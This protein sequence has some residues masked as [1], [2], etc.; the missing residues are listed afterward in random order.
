MT[1]E[2][3]T[4]EQFQQRQR[5]RDERADVAEEARA[6]NEDYV[7][8]LRLL[9]TQQNSPWGTTAEV[10]LTRMSML[11]GLKKALLGRRF[12]RFPVE[13]VE[14]DGMT[15]WDSAW[16][17]DSGGG[18]LN[19]F[20]DLSDFACPGNG[21]LVERDRWLAVSVVPVNP[22]VSSEFDLRMKRGYLRRCQGKWHMSDDIDGFGPVSQWTGIHYFPIEPSLLRGPR[23]R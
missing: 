18:D 16:G 12:L 7:S 19:P 8:M 21:P 9:N 15:M 22:Y 23:F 3:V 14:V 10:S 1:G 20:A 4:F 11:E 6:E 17:V 2:I 13:T 5:E